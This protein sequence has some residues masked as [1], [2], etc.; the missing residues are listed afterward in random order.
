MRVLMFFRVVLLPAR[1]LPTA[2][3][4]PSG[5]VLRSTTKLVS[6]VE[7]SLNVR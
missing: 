2:V 3:N 4:G 6:V 1:G 7:L 5:L